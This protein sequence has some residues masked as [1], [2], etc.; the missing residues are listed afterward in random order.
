[1]VNIVLRADFRAFRRAGTHAIATGLEAIAIACRLESRGVLGIVGRTVTII[2][3]PAMV[4]LCR[5]LV[6]DQVEA[7]VAVAPRPAV[8]DDIARLGGFLHMDAETVD[9]AAI[10]SF[11]IG[12]VVVVGIAV[13]HEVVGTRCLV[14]ANGHAVVHGNVLNDAMRSLSCRYAFRLGMSLDSYRQTDDVEV[15]QVQV[16]GS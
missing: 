10:F 15:A 14:V 5:C 7:V 6:V 3:S 8:A 2:K 12:V 13:Q 9:I 11:A 16:V 4:E 1:M